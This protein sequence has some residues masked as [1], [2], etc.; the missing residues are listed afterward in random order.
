MIPLRLWHLFVSM[1]IGLVMGIGVENARWER[2][3]EKKPI[4]PDATLERLA[5]LEAW[6]A[7]QSSLKSIGITAERLDL[8]VYTPENVGKE[9]IK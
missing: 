2:V 9:K 4:T 7:A 6:V 3:P 1:I 8:H 5:K